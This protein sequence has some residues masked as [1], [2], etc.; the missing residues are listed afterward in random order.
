M[1]SENNSIYMVLFSNKPE[2]KEAI[3]I[4]DE[5]VSLTETGHY[6]QLNDG[7]C[8]IGRTGVE[9]N[10]QLLWRHAQSV[11]NECLRIYGAG[12]NRPTPIDILSAL[13]NK[14][15][16][17]GNTFKKKSP[18]KISSSSK[19]G[20]KLKRKKRK[21]RKSISPKEKDV[22]FKDNNL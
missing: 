14:P 10:L 4:N 11:Y 15:G 18:T 13:K 19:K 9:P 5:T 12:C 8:Y 6:Y 2:M 21:K 17:T 1:D 16:K 22:K 7:V 3:P 20:G